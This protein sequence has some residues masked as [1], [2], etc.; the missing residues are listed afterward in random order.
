MND[1]FY[2]ILGVS[3]KSS[4]EEI[5]KSYRALS[6]KYHPDKNPGNTECVAKFQKINEAYETLGDDDKRRD[7][8]NEN[9]N[10]FLKMARQG[11]MGGMNMGGMGGMNMGGMNMGGMNMGG[12]NMGG[13]NMGGMEGMNNIDELFNSIFQGGPFGMGM[14][15]F[16]NPNAN[17]HVFHNGKKINMN[18]IQK[19]QPI[20]E[21]IVISMEQVLNGANIPINIERWIIENG[22]KI[23]EHETIYVTIPQGIDDNE[24]ILVKDKGNSINETC[25]GDIKIFIKI[26]NTTYFER[27]GL[28]LLINQKITLKEALCGF[29]FELK[30]INDKVYTVNNNIGNV[31]TPGYKKIIK[32]MGL[33]RD[34]H[35][36]NLIINFT[37]DFPSDLT[38]E[39][40]NSLQE[41]L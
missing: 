20:N 11:G 10:P 38:I 23:N 14:P 29:S 16:M 35:V 30:Y 12:M 26:E 39:Q 22:N 9:N 17:I 36:G 8:D 7:Y 31:I 6:M 32:N 4:K 5:K 19:P 25:K 2:N 3:E 15:G 27:N 13:M 41:I 18:N 1:S 21:T 34:N 33:T 37:I 40:I 28:D 24:I